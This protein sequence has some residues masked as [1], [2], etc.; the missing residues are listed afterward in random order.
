MRPRHIIR[1]LA[2]LA[3]GAVAVPGLSG[4]RV[5]G[6]DLVTITNISQFYLRR[7]EG[8]G[9]GAPVQIR[10]TVTY[11]DFGW[12]MLFLQDETDAMMVSSTGI[13]AEPKSGDVVELTARAQLEDQSLAIIQPSL[14]VLQRGGNPKPIAANGEELISG[15]RSCQW[16]ELKCLIRQMEVQDTRLKVELLCGQTRLGSYIRV[17]P[18]K[19]DINPWIGATVKVQ[20]VCANH[21]EGGKIVGVGLFIPDITNLT[22]ELRPE[23]SPTNLPVQTIRKVIDHPVIG[24]KAALIRI[25]GRVAGKR[26]ATSTQPNALTI[27]DETGKVVIKSFE[28]Q[29]FNIDDWVDVRGFPSMQHQEVILEDAMC[30]PLVRQP[31]SAAAEQLKTGEGMPEVLR[32]I[33]EV[34]SLSRDQA[35]RGVGVRLQGVVTYAN[36]THQQLFLQDATGA[37]YVRLKHWPEGLQAGQQ[38]ELEGKTSPGGITH[39]VVEATPRILGATNLPPPLQLGLKS[40]ISEGYDCSWVELEGVVRNVVTGPPMVVLRL[41]NDQGSFEAKLPESRDAQLLH[42]LVDARVRVRGVCAGVL[43]DQDQWIGIELRMPNLGAMEIREAAPAEPFVIEPRPVAAISRG[44]SGL[45]GLHR[46]RVKGVVTLVADQNEF[47]LQDASGAI[48]VNATQTNAVEVGQ[49]LDVAGFPVQDLFSIRLEEAWFRPCPDR[50][51]VSAKLAQAEEVISRREFDRELITVRGRL[52]NDAGGSTLLSFLIQDGLAEFTAQFETGDR[53]FAL[54]VWRR[55][56]ELQLTGVCTFRANERNEPRSF[57]LLLRQPEDVVMLRRPPWWTPQHAVALGSGLVALAL[58]ALAWVLLLRVRVGEQTRQIRQRLESEAALEKRL[59]HVWETSAD[60]MRMTDAMGMTISVNEAYCKIVERKRA[61]LE[62]YPFARIYQVE[63]QERITEAYRT[64]FE[65]REIQPRLEQRLVLWNGRAV[66][67]ELTNTFIEPSESSAMMLSQ[68]RDVTPR[69]QAEDALRESEAKI[70]SIIRAAPIGIGVV[71]DRMI[72]EVNDGVCEMTQYTRAELIGQSA[73]IFYCSQEEFERVGKIKYAQIADHGAGVVET[74]WQRKDGMVRDILLSSAPIDPAELARGVSFC[75]LDITA[76]QRALQEIS[77]WKQRYDLLALSAG[78]VVYDYS[79]KT[80]AITWGGGINSLLGFTSDD[81]QGG[82]AQWQELVHPDD[83]EATMLLLRAAETAG[84][85]FRGEF[86]FR[87]QQGH[88][89]MV[90]DTGY[91][92]FDEHHYVDRYI[93][94]LVD[95]T[96]RVRVEKEREQLENQLRQ[97]QK[98]ESVGRLAGGVAHDFNN[99]LQVIL[100]N[101]DLALSD[102]ALLQGGLRDSLEEIRKVA[103]RSADLTR[104][105]LAFARKQTVNPK[106][107]DLNEVV[108]GMLRMLQRLIGEEIQLSWVPGSGLWAV[109]IDPS[110]LDQILANLTV[111]ARDAIGG[112]GKITLLTANKILDAHITQ[113]HPDGVPGDYVMLAVTD[114]GH[115]LAP[116]ARDHLFEPFFTTKENGQ[117]TGLGLATVYGIVKQNH[118]LIDVDSKPGQHTTFRIYFPRAKAALSGAMP[119]KPPMAL[120]GAETVLLVEDEESVLKL[121]QRILRQHG[122]NVLSASTPQTAVALA[123]QHSGRIHLLITD[124]VMPGMNGK[125]L[126]LQIRAIQPGMRCMYMSGYTADVIARHGVLDNGVEFI[127]KPFSAQSLAE[128]VRAVLTPRS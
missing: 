29:S 25:Q 106:V 56:S 97:A 66:W 7:H 65:H 118:G 39:M 21:F 11:A 69:R 113:V 50:L 60:G 3:W 85:V 30:T 68:F 96:E 80:E 94:V 40:L 42:N 126:S 90:Q 110:Q 32:N 72:T 34:R 33:R 83:R 17:A 76:R 87:H 13:P 12:G 89:L 63:D 84:S 62:G 2:L 111:N 1:N 116:E 120:Q 4:D 36:S 41:V 100:G 109:Q 55:G 74:R 58:A 95:I 86:R 92:L 73:R 35:A 93:G 108:S 127:S 20:G 71:T 46:V 124:V 123:R 24:E 26:G 47:C 14:R 122:Y 23:V 91:P 115:G 114:T 19:L 38:V 119:S 22:V 27:Q 78:N 98:M 107:L 44:A 53:K 31:A 105:L 52:L 77:E 57:V 28:R 43:N 121:G 16:V 9:A 59:S 125:E 6:A 5:S 67:F 15:K 64:R 101:V 82:L 54:P 81:L 48:R 102:S 45:L 70:R 75:A 61:E 37:V 112:V 88:Y 117:G 99:M 51:V 8:S 104:Q 128:K 18:S 49:V 79:V 103:Q 10:A